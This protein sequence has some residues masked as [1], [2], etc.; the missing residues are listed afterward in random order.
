MHT[1]ATLLPEELPDD[2]SVF[3]EGPQTDRFD[4]RR[5]RSQHG[6]CNDRGLDRVAIIFFELL[7]NLVRRRCVG[8]VQP[9]DF[10][11]VAVS[12]HRARS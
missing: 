12:F 8:G 5:R 10:P 1:I 11:S 3:S 6:E 9:A 4:R 2:F 7:A